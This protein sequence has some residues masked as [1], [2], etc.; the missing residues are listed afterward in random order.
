MQE[1]TE[2]IELASSAILMAYTK[3]LI[4]YSLGCERTRT[5]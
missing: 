3:I 4:A 1:K 2:L 5:S